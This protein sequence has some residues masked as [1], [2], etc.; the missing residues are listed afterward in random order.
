MKVTV[1]IPNYNG[2]EYLRECL[3]SLEEQSFKEFVTLIVDNCSADGSR[4]FIKENYPE[5]RLIEMDK[6]YGFSI[7]V[8]KGI[9][10][11]RTEYVILLNNDTVVHKDYIKELYNHISS[12][13][14]IFSV[15]S[16]M[17]SYHDRSVMDDAGDMY[18]VVGWAFQ[19]GTGQPVERY[20]EPCRVFSA[21][22][23]AAIYRRE[24]F[25]KIGL[26]DE[27]HF[28]YLEDIDVG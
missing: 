3:K 7:A 22:A 6:N 1:V 25:K 19:R 11:S 4:E 12:S 5:I 15:S 24:V 14:R 18:S 13:K 9:R 16:R 8:N 20:D 2:I 17:I 28:A 10:E 26:F 23:G 27:M 21:C